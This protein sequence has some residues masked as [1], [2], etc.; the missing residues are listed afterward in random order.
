MSY[1]KKI[2]KS[3]VTVF[4]LS[5]LGALMGYLIR[6]VLARNLS[7]A[8]YGLFYAILA[9]FGLLGIFKDLGLNAAL[10]KYIS[11]FNI[12]KKYG[13][14]KSSIISV[15][16]LQ[17]IS[18]LFL[19]IILIFLSG[20]LAKNYFHEPTATLIFKLMLIYFCLI[21]L[22]NVIRF[23]FQGFQRMFYYGSMNFVKM[24]IILVITLLFFH[25]GFSIFAPVIAYM[26]VSIFE[27]LIYFPIFFKKTIPFFFEIKTK[28]PFSLIKKLMKFG[29]PTM[30]GLLGMLVIT[31]TDTMILTYFRPLS[32]VGLYQV[33]IPTAA[34]LLYFSNALTSIVF[35]VYSEMWVKKEKEKLKKGLELLHK[36]SLIIILPISLT[37]FSFPNVI[38]NLFFGQKY[39]G[40]ALPLQILSIGMIF[41][42]IGYLN[43]NTI[44]AIGKPKISSKVVIIAA[45]I[46]LIGN[47]ILIPIL[48]IVGAALVTSFSYIILFL[49]SFVYSRKYFKIDVNLINWV[50]NIALGLIFIAVI[51]L[52]KRI[53]EINLWLEALIALTIAGLFYI[54]G[55]FLFRI[56]NLKEILKFKEDLLQRRIV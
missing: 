32:D 4:L 39:L 8:E 42:S 17:T 52:L 51:F 27:A 43:N 54:I 41:Y 53:L 12:K 23:T 30:F 26:A 24:S 18:S 20:F 11:E 36:Y 5:I 29:I 47:L 7:T 56:I 21:P 49:L 50:K 2:F 55:L 28:I 10:P 15:F 34:L 1:A 48:G 16:S 25:L 33:A 45:M 35:P 44:S 31:Y 14:I 19:A 13:L 3:T 6:M 9:F 38:I 40:A 22:E 37:M 46:N